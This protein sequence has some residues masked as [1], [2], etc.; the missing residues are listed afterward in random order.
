MAAIIH[1]TSNYTTNPKLLEDLIDDVAIYSEFSK[2]IE[3]LQ[4]LNAQP[5]QVVMDKLF[6]EIE[7]ITKNT[8]LK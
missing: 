6:N 3:L 1:E 5:D 7:I 2:E 4:Y 8:S